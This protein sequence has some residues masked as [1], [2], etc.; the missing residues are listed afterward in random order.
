MYSL[1]L[2]IIYIAFISIGLPDSLIGSAWPIMH[3]DLQVPVS[4]MGIITMLI[5]GLCGAPLR[6]PPHELAALLLG[7]R[8][9]RQ[10]LHHELCPHRP[11]RLGPGLPHCVHT[12]DSANCRSVFQSSP[13]EEGR[14]P[15][16]AH[17][18]YRCS[19]IRRNCH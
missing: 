9:L 12:T 3:R 8:L 17:C 18:G 2:V 1:L 16:T 15:D 5:S 4:Y 10:P 19:R 7:C 11:L 14:R 6:I 13:M